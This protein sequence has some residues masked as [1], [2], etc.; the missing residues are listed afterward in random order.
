M[1]IRSRWAC[2]ITY[3]NDRTHEIIRGRAASLAHVQRWKSRARARATALPLRIRWVRFADRNAH[4]IFLEPEGLKA[5]EVY[6]NGISTSL[7]FDTQVELVRSIAGL[8]DAE[9]TRPGYAIEYDY[10]D[11]AGSRA[12]PRESASAGGCCWPAKLTARPAMKKRRH[13]AF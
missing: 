3:T 12:H 10:L 9:I 4:Q 8:E 5:R 13:R 11:P 7:P 6:P 1:S 2:H